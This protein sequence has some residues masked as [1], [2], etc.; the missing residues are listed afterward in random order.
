MKP[1]F[2][3]IA[4]MG[5]GAFIV[6]GDFTDGLLCLTIATVIGCSWDIEKRLRDE[7]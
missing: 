7:V 3:T 6:V 1:L 2:F 5:C 4:A